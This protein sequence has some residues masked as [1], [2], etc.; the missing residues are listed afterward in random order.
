MRRHSY[1]HAVTQ[2]ATP[3]FMLEHQ[4]DATIQIQLEDGG[5]KLSTSTFK[6]KLRK[7]LGTAKKKRHLA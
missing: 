2:N 7:S 3:I 1:L 5:Y 6:A 4:N